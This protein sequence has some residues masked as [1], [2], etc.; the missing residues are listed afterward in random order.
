MDEAS[1]LRYLSLADEAGEKLDGPE[2]DR[3]ADRLE[4][5]H[6]RLGEAFDWLASHQRSA[7]ALRLAA[8]IWTFQFDR[9]YAEEGRCWLSL[10][11]DAPGAAAP[12]AVRATALYAAGTFAF[13]A[14]D[15]E[16]AKRY[17]EELLDVARSLDDGSLVGQ[18]YG[19]LARVALRRGDTTEVRRWSENALELARQRSSEAATA[20]PLH[21]LAAAARLDGDLDGARRL[22][23]ENLELN[24]RLGRSSWVRAETL[25][26]A[27]IE[28]LRGSSDDAIPLLRESLRLVRE[29]SDRYL[30]PYVMAWSARAALARGEAALA[31]RLLGV[32]Q[33]QSERTGLAMDPDEEPE[34]HRG[35]SACRAALSAGD[36]EQMWD[37]GLRTS[38]EESLGLADR[39]LSVP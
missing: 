38:D 32:A 8:R 21:M 33:A 20:T 3:W 36:F 39:F 1:A 26:L 6:E 22:Y 31:T 2:G 13:R 12:T 34:F 30:M 28:V 14:L 23:R 25:N 16:R 27:A 29:S 24:R 15:Q 4:Q 18:A 11:L 37:S 7:E 35:V 19:G 5:E 9:G 17:F 10:A